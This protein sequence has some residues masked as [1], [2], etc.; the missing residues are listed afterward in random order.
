[1]I[2][3]PGFQRRLLAVFAHPD[4]ETFGPGGT[5]ALCAQQ[6]VE[7]YLVCATRGE[8]GEAPPDLRG[9]A[10]VEE[11][12]E[13]ELRCASRVLGL[14]QVCFLGY[15]D[16]G[17]AGSPENSHP[18]STAKAP[19]EEIAR[20]V[21]R[22]IRQIRPQVIITSDPSGGYGHPDH[23]AVH[24]ATV[25]A[26][27]LAGDARVEMDGLAPYCPQKL[28]YHTF[29]LSWVKPLVRVLQWFGADLRHFG[30]N[31]DV[32]L[33]AI[34][35]TDLPVH[36]TISVRSV[37]H[38][39]GEASRCHASQGAGMPPGAMAWMA[40]VLLINEHFSRAVPAEP[41]GHMERDLFEGVLQE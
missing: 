25:E 41:P 11:M 30:K 7:T 40:R 28:Y 37:A 10:S 31:G 35:E 14:K 18:D 22:H 3:Q 15:R 19:L 5:L 9:Y 17:M 34:V 23:I 8:A 24:R 36:A 32:D 26:F 27:R 12:R 2:S 4:D 33:V 38:L 13:A 20:K 16:S 1:M 29:P 39:K 6:G 21:A